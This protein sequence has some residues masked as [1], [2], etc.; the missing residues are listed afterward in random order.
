MRVKIFLLN[1][2][3]E[4]WTDLCVGLLQTSESPNTFRFQVCAEDNSNE[5]ALD[6]EVYD[7]GQY[8]RQGPTIIRFIHPEP[9]LASQ[10]AATG[11]SDPLS[12]GNNN[13]LPQGETCT[14]TPPGQSPDVTSLALSFEH[15]AQ[16]TH[17]WTC[18]EACLPTA[19]GCVFVEGVQKR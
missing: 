6:H 13:C 16:C 1:E 17:I 9:M 11:A 10:E 2:E 12:G 5:I 8:E 4:E 18:I 7:G 19:A 3:S 15:P 14:A